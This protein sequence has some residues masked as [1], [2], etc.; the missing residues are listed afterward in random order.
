M[1]DYLDFNMRIISFIGLGFL[2]ALA[3]TTL[4]QSGDPISVTPLTNIGLASSTPAD[5]GGFINQLYMYGI[6]VGAIA[7]VIVLII[8]GFKYMTSQA[9]GGKS[10]GRDEITRAVLGLLLLL[11]PVIVFNV[12]NSD[13]TKF[14]LDLS[15][16]GNVNGDPTELGVGV[17]QTCSTF[18]FTQNDRNTFL[19]E[20]SE[21]IPDDLS[22]SVFGQCCS[23]ANCLLK[24]DSIS[25]GDGTSSARVGCDC[26]LVRMQIA[27]VGIEYENGD[28][29]EPTVGS[30]YGLYSDGWLSFRKSIEPALCDAVDKN[31]GSRRASDIVTELYFEGKL[32]WAG[33]ALTDVF[34]RLGGYSGEPPR[35]EEISRIIINPSILNPED[36]TCD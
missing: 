22:Q 4:A 10:D 34:G 29:I 35:V 9:P 8:G 16:G 14:N 26:G 18:E 20:K 27:L 36:I 25:N 17:N 28:F 33:E 30:K 32:R 7:A 3:G 5:I 15:F 24:S 12:I 21:N 11:S 23:I 1:K 19:P 2:L 31:P 13:I 6:G